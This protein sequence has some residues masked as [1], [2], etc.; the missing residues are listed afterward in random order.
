MS[1]Y[2]TG[3]G[4]SGRLDSY[5]IQISQSSSYIQEYPGIGMDAGFPIFYFVFQAIIKTTQRGSQEK[6]K[7]SVYSSYTAFFMSVCRMRAEGSSVCTS[8]G[9]GFSPPGSAPAGVPE[10]ILRAFS[11]IRYRQ[12]TMNRVIKSST[13]AG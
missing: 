7:I 5:R 3:K 8:T 12:P 11:R 10:R 1:F 9:S 4:P 6:S 2:R 13:F